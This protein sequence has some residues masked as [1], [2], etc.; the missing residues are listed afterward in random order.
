LRRRRLVEF[1]FLPRTRRPCGSTLARAI[2]TTDT[3]GNALFFG[4]TRPVC[5]LAFTYGAVRSPLRLRE[6][7]AFF[8]A[9]C[10]THAFDFDDAIAVG[11]FG[12]SSRRRLCDRLLAALA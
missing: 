5:D 3:N 2:G 7:S 8:N 11:Y 4:V 12:L 10:R 1:L 9:G 6:S